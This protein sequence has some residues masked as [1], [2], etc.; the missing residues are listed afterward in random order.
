MLAPST[1]QQKAVR[2]ARSARTTGQRSN[3]SS[4]VRV[5]AASAPRGRSRRRPDRR[6]FPSR[7]R[8]TRSPS[9][10]RRAGQAQRP[11]AADIACN[12][13]SSAPSADHDAAA[14]DGRPG[15]QLP[16]CGGRV[17][18]AR[19]APSSSTVQRP[20]P[21]EAERIRAVEGERHAARRTR[22]ARGARRV[23]GASRPSAPNTRSGAHDDAV[24]EAAFVLGQAHGDRRRRR[25][26][27]GCASPAA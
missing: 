7:D 24:V 20:S 18:A 23:T 4:H 9:R 22:C 13:T 21:A 6:G 8:R 12:R 17:R 19:R 25:A 3:Q 2:S 16:A 14:A 26:A 1:H 11:D 27:P 15:A 10:R 5:V